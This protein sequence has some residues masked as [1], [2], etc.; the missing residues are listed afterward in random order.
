MKKL[1]EDDLMP[2]FWLLDIWMFFLLP[3]L[4]SGIVEETEERMV[5]PPP[6]LPRWV[7]PSTHKICLF[8]IMLVNK[9]AFVRREVLPP[10]GFRWAYAPPPEV[11]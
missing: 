10:G 2:W 1:K 8:N 11:V 6:D 7:K 4:F 5:K 3:D 9:L